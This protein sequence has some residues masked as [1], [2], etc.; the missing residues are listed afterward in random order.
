MAGMGWDAVLWEL[1][2][3][4][5]LFAQIKLFVVLKNIPRDIYKNNI[6]A[7]ILVC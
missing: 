6:V 2:A 5:S 3:P 7:Y 4:V 1:L